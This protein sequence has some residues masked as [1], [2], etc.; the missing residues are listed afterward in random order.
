M[1]P[2]LSLA[3]GYLDQPVPQQQLNHVALRQVHQHR[4]AVY[5]EKNLGLF[6]V[7]REW[8]PTQLN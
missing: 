8:N 2:L 6:D 4:W 5:N 1:I 7:D 3:W